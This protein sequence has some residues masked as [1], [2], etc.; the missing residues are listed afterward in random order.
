MERFQPRM[1][2]NLNEVDILLWRNDDEKRFMMK[3]F[4]N[5]AMWTAALAGW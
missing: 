3:S 2:L 5:T 4:E 1:E